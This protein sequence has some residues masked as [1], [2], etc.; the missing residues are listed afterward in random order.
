MIDNN[1]LY[2]NSGVNGAGKSTT[3][4]M[5]TGYSD[6]TYGDAFIRGISVRKHWQKV[7]ID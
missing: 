7:F 4:N 6:I 3:F 1:S 2:L 5:L